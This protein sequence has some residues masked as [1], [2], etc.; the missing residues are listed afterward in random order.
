[1]PHNLKLLG[2][3][4]LLTQGGWTS[5]PQNRSFFLHCYLSYQAQWVSRE[6]ILLLF[7]PDV[8]E[9]KARQ[10]LRTLLYKLKQEAF[11]ES[12]EVT[13]TQLR[14]L[15]TTDVQQ[16]QEALTLGDWSTAVKSYGGPF[17]ERAHDDSSTFDD[18]LSQTRDELHT[19]WQDAA[20]HVAQNHLTEGRY[21]EAV[22]LL[23]AILGYDFLAE[24]VVQACMKAQ[25]LAGQKTAALNTF[26][27]FKKQ[28]R[29]E[30]EMEP[31]EETLTLFEE[32]NN[33]SL[34]VP[35]VP[36]TATP[37]TK[38]SYKNNLPQT[39]TPFVGRTLELLELA[40]LLAEPETRLITLL[41]PGGIGKSRLSLRLLKE[42]EE[43][44]SGGVTFVRLAPL[45]SATDIPAAT[46][47]ALGLQLSG[48]SEV[49]E[50]VL[51]Y[52]EQREMLLVF[53][54]FEHVLE[55]ASLLQQ[56]LEKARRCKIIVTSRVL[57]NLPN[58]RVYDVVGLSI[59]SSKDD[60]S[61]EA[62]DAAQFFLR[63]ARRVRSDFA[64]TEQDKAALVE[65]CLELQGMPLA[66]ELAATW[67]RV[68]SLPELVQ[69][70]RQD[71][72]VLETKGQEVSER[73]R[74]IRSVFEH[75][76]NLLTSE[77][78][79]VL[80]GLSIFHGG[81]DR[82]A[83]Q[84][85]TG[86]S[87]RTLLSLV[88]KSLV[89]TLAS[90]RFLMLEVIRQC[91]YIKLEQ[92]EILSEAHSNYYF[93]YVAEKGRLIRSQGSKEH[94]LSLEVNLEN[95]RFAWRWAVAQQHY[96]KLELISKH[97]SFYFDL[98]ARLQEGIRLFQEA[99]DA[100]PK[101]KHQ[102]T[103]ANLMVSQAVLYRWAGEFETVA[104]LCENA[105][106]LIQPEDSPRDYITGLDN[107]A[108]AMEQK[109]NL[110][111]AL[112]YATQE[113]HIAQQSHDEELVL[114]GTKTLAIVEDLSGNIETARTLYRAALTSYRKMGDP[115][116][117]MEI[118]SNVGEMTF[119]QGQTQEA[120]EMFE[121]AL[122][123]ARANGDEGF[124]YIC[125]ANL[126][127]CAFELG[128][129]KT[130]QN[131]YQ[132]ALELVRQKGNQSNEVLYLAELARVE[133]ALSQIAPAI[134]LLKQATALAAKT[135]TL[136]GLMSC[137]F[138]WAEYFLACHKQ[139]A[140]LELLQLLAVNPASNALHKR[141]ATT[142][143]KN[144]AK[145]AT[146]LPSSDFDAYYQHLAVILKNL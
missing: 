27:T 71:V 49:F 58:E 125:L 62:Y 139:E 5:P 123:L 7:W 39:L 87:V 2:N 22:D 93:N 15:A 80:A 102:K 68:F 3:P 103:L 8:R 85:V 104:Q 53:D 19:A 119:E 118:L 130:A 76:W 6:E 146:S 32:I 108:F 90:G 28:L 111:K 84:V 44:F 116:G 72:D 128:D 24:E 51:R 79:R 95:I 107:L 136:S 144:F 41:G 109:G 138:G 131:Y 99:I 18:W 13:E 75:S 137:Y 29:D 114:Q 117:T 12:L 121:E 64:L 70:I 142:I 1:M 48:E 110:K 112:E 133:L 81:F 69:E 100:L 43:K 106:S 96:E 134:T 126:G 129:P 55:G 63:S 92:K 127:A 124:P 115:I 59:P 83:A 77:E 94:L 120:R 37:E 50:E 143:L 132:E 52:L 67:V 45:G 61:I 66:L 56:L 88:N 91:A 26:A 98:R 30:L 140:G 122:A 89:R 101:G 35:T 54:N 11:A 4:A 33:L 65:L 46:A 25:A 31:L 141:K 82:Q 86:A 73:H 57:L 78:Q 105:L 47:S 40:N 135:K 16:F 74:S 36:L 20:L 17:L 10:N 21:S 97:L 34:N 14:W 38:A 42:Q 113:Y 145:P 60:L 23:Q 9:S